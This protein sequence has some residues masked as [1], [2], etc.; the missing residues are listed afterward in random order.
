MVLSLCDE[1]AGMPPACPLGPSPANP[2]GSPCKDLRT[3]PSVRQPPEA[4]SD[5]CMSDLPA[6][7]ITQERV[8]LGNN[9]ALQEERSG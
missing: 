2:R 8:G 6:F 9:K 3:P 1:Y 5:P 7:V 4:L